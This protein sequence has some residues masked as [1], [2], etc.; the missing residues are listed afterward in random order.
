MAMA[1][2]AEATVTGERV[3]P[4]ALGRIGRVRRGS[5]FAVR[6]VDRAGQ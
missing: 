3:R 2:A 1:G 6:R 4:A 5:L